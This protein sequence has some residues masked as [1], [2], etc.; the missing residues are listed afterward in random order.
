MVF[1]AD[2][3]VQARI[4]GDGEEL[5]PKGANHLLTGTAGPPWAH[6]AERMRRILGLKRI[7]RR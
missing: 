1:P 6:S 3:R 4:Q 5:V 7:N 2:E